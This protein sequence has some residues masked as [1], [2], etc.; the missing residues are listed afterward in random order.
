MRARARGARHPPPCPSSARR[1][2]GSRGAADARLR[3][4]VGLYFALESRRSDFADALVEEEAE[5]RAAR[6]LCH[7]RVHADGGPRPGDCDEPGAAREDAGTARAPS[8]TSPAAAR[9][10]TAHP[11]AARWKRTRRSTATA[12]RTAASASRAVNPLASASRSRPRRARARR[13]RQKQVDSFLAN[14]GV[15][16]ATSPPRAPSAEE[17]RGEAVEAASGKKSARAGGRAMLKRRA[18]APPSS[19]IADGSALDDDAGGYRRRRARR[20]A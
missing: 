1:D 7:A 5:P 12:R 15:D 11:T 14:M 10:L 17:A 19:T 4:G 2:R 13:A 8:L 18:N 6:R 3:G 9:A 16:G 20:R